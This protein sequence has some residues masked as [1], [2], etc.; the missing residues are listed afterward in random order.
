MVTATVGIDAALA[1]LQGQSG[2][3]VRAGIGIIPIG[4]AAALAKAAKAAEKAAEATKAAQGLAKIGFRSDG[5][6]I[7]RKATGHLADDTA[8]NRALI[9][10]ALD[11]ANLRDTITLNNGTTLQKHFRDLPDVTQ[12]WAEVRNGEIT[13]G[14]LN[15]ISR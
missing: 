14:G 9:K 1:C 11:P 8:E 2:G 12:A 6:H 13:N 3:C 15:V 10:S 4:K 5:A 7:F